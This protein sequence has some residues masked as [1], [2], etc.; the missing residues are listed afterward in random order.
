MKSV[1]SYHCAL[2]P[3]LTNIILPSPFSILSALNLLMRVYLSHITL[4]YKCSSVPKLRFQ[5]NKKENT[6][7][8]TAFVEELDLIPL[9]PKSWLVKSMTIDVA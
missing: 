2:S 5:N 8:L 9:I 4:H 6:T 7:T 3:F 1:P